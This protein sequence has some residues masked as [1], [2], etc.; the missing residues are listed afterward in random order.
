MCAFNS[1]PPIS[2]SLGGLH[3]GGGG[4]RL[5]KKKE[6]KESLGCLGFCKFV[7]EV[8]FFLYHHVICF[9]NIKLTKEPEDK[10]K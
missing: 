4:R 8:S 10:V 5:F 7:P 9:L 3:C 6:R 2:M 1:R